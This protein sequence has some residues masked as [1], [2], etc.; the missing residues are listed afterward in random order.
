MA[1]N[2]LEELESQLADER[3]RVDVSSVT[4]SVR[5]LV[6]MFEEGELR[7]APSYQRKYRWSESVASTFIE[8]IFLGL[9]VPPIFVATNED[10]ELEVVD[11]LQR[12]STLLMFLAERPEFLSTVNRSKPLR[13]Q[14]LETLDQLNGLTHAELPSS[15]Q[16]YFGRQPLQV[17]SLTDKS[18]RA[19]RFDLFERLN[20]GAIALSA[21]EVRAAVYRGNFNDLLE[22]LSVYPSFKALLK[23]QE[24]N[25]HDG[26]AAE[27][28]LKY[29]AY[30]N[31]REHFR[32]SVT[33]FLNSYAELA[34]D[35]FDYRTEREVFEKTFDF[36]HDCTEGPFL[37][38][39]TRVTPLVEF[40]ACGVAIGSLVEERIPVVEPPN[41]WIEDIELVKASTGGSNTRQMLARRVSRARA[42]FSGN[43]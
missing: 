29:F 30:K 42:L 36:L 22:E 39:T 25:K 9:P 12:I 19:V 28:V 18:D 7:I 13:L 37:R 32:G 35:V 4:F 21:Q 41:G 1:I 5:E 14:G 31:H 40:E 8:S 10:F 33:K 34:N 26:T 16:R 6:R 3:R 27:Q 11:G 2:D 38:K 20:A 17:I 43:G 23:L 24:V 15:L